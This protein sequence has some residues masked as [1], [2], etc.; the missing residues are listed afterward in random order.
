MVITIIVLLGV[1]SWIYNSPTENGIYYYRG[2]EEVI[3]RGRYFASL[4]WD[5]CHVN[6][7]VFQEVA[8]GTAARKVNEAI[9]RNSDHSARDARR[10]AR[11][12]HLERGAGLTVHQK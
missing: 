1:G 10:K 6:K 5:V 9:L 12:A 2:Q 4:L 8:V 3:H 7:R 11:N